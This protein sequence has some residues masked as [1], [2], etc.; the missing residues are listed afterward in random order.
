VLSSDLNHAVRWRLIEHN[1]CKDVSPPSVPAPEI[2]P[3]SKEEAKRFLAAA[4]SDRQHALYVLS[5]TS[6]VL[7]GELNG[8]F[9]GDLYLDR[10][11]VYTACPQARYGEYSFEEPKT[12]G[13][14]RSV[15]LTKLAAE[16]LERHRERQASEGFPVDVDALAFTNNV[17]KPYTNPT[18]YVARSPSL[19]VLACRTRT[20]TR[21]PATPARAFC[22]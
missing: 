16:A 13:R 10:R 9:W 17:G 12:K 1:V 3:F 20:G 7:W 22:C 15:G 11:V 14:R 8:L 4:E 19:N 2:R 5:V 18:S 21:Q 6:G